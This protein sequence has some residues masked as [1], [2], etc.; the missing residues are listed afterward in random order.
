MVE[1]LLYSFIVL[2]NFSSF[3]ISA[4]TGSAAPGSSDTVNAV[5]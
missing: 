2:L 4:A 3:F 5:D 1:C